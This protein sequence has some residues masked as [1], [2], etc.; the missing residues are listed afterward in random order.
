[1]ENPLHATGAGTRGAVPGGAEPYREATVMAECPHGH[2]LH[3]VSRR[4][5]R[6]LVEDV[7]YKIQRIKKFNR[8][9]A[10]TMETVKIP[11]FVEREVDVEIIDYVCDECGTTHTIRTAQPAAPDARIPPKG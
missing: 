10:E 4:C 3:E 8:E 5:V 9:G 6:E 2:P 7:V 11:E 1:M